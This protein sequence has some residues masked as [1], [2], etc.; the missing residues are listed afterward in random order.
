MRLI[1]SYVF[2]QPTSGTH[3]SNKKQSGKKEEK[4]TS[5]GLSCVKAEI[6]AV[7][8]GGKQISVFLQIDN[9]GIGWCC[10]GKGEAL[11]YP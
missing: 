9:R 7:T 2:A 10:E 3:I 6:T 1:S 8:S 4:E 5:D 11:S